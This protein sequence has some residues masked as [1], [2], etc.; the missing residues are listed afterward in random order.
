[1]EEV[2]ARIIEMPERYERLVETGRAPIK[3]SL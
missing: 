1:M 3:S 2:R